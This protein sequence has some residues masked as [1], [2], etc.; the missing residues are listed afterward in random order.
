V[1]TTRTSRPNLERLPAAHGLVAR[2]LL[3][4]RLSAAG[5]GAVILVCGPA[6]SGKTA[7]VRSWVESDEPDGRVAWVSVERGERD[8]QRF[9]LS[10]IDEL[11]AA[12]GRDEL[13]ERVAAT[14][15]F[16]GQAVVERLLS[17]LHS[18][19][20]PVVL[21]IDD[22]NEL[23]SDDA[24]RWLD[25]FVAGLPPELRLV[26]VTRE[27]PSR[28]LHGLRLAGRLT[29]IRAPDL[30]FSL[31]ETRQ[32]MDSSGVPLSE[33]ALALLHERTEG[34]AAGLRLAAISLASHPEPERFV[35]EFC[36]SERTV[37]GYLLAE[38]LE[39]Q[40]AEVRD[41]LLRTSILERVSGPLADAL[42]G[43]KGSE[44]ILQRLEDAN[45][46][47]TALDVGR[48]W[49]RYHHLLS[50]LL[51]LELRRASP[52]LVASLHRA[53]AQWLDEHGHVVEAIRHA[54]SAAD[55]AHGAGLLADNYVDL[56]FDGRKATLRALLTA[57]PADASQADAEL[58]LAFGTARLY[59][60]LLD[61]VP[62]Y[63]AVAERL[64]ATVP[65]DRRRLFDLQLTSARLWL[66]C[67]RGDLDAARQ[68]IRSLQAQAAAM[69]G[70]RADD[71]R[72]SALMNFGIA[73]LWSLQVD[74]AH[75]DLEEALALA[76][77]IGRRYLEIECLG[78]LALAAVIAGSPV[79]VGLE[80]SEEAVTLAE[81]HGWGTH[82]IVAPAVAAGAAALAWLG[83]I[84]EA[85]LWLE[86]GEWTQAEELEMEPVL[87]YVRG[88]VRLGQGRFEDAL[89][90]FRAAETVGPSLAREHVLPGEVRGWILHTQALLGETAAVRATLEGLDAGERDGAAM[91]IAA[92]AVA[93]ADGRPQDVVDVLA[94]MIA[95][96]PEP[97][98]DGSAQVLN[99]RRATVHA[100][101]L[102]AAA[103]DRLGQPGAA[104][105]S[106][107]RALDLAERDGTILQFLL[108]PV[109]ELLERHPRH[110]TAHGTLLAAIR[111]LLRGSSRGPERAAAPLRDELSEAELR[112]VRYLPSNLKAS[113]IAAELYVSANTVR[114][115]LRHIYAKL[116]AHSRSEAVA[117]ARELR[118]LAPGGG[119][120]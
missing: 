105:A 78:H 3:F 55:W 113:E 14:P 90:E 67:Q 109:R 101:L 29:E 120:G 24:L 48:T 41:L 7:L 69:G 103:R 31:Q 100:L 60:G 45:A 71:H 10:V 107:E 89:A 8:A 38:V 91:R 25:L 42:T 15:A 22:L 56:V 62:A 35:A 74:D 1:A 9:W 87:R 88:F 57:F 95:D 44:A 86:R 53:A 26:I 5:P 81:G 94:P 27:E 50:D 93:L 23:R 92:A 65:G 40:P 46:F 37:A 75:R 28:G 112:V 99:L 39:R 70:R 116:D 96:V 83:R 18:L 12:I 33:A 59:D 54:Q 102:D 51:Q 84:D 97:A 61:E 76:R 47:V 117:R 114:T 2:R 6:G 58:A 72:A 20:Q 30:R 52:A 108:V 17:D 115:H 110:R 64:A 85:E 13:V 82:R 32:L 106:I 66:A 104:E 43:G 73:E 98:V 21:V 49:F 118:L 4:D 68:A 80:R 119:S 111:D 36:G 11:A 16:E 63:L 79:H 34:W 19:E 77:R